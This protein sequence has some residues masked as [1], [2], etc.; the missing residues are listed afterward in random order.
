[1]YDPRNVLKQSPET[2]RDW[3]LTLLA[4]LV[5]FGVI[6]MSPEATAVSGVLVYKTLTLLYVAP[7]QKAKVEADLSALQ[8]LADSTPASRAAR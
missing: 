2:V 4:A 7:T 1:M 3:V 6:T 8:D 5:V